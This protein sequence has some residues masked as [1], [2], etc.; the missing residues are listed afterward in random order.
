MGS[1]IRVAAMRGY[2]ELVTQLGADPTQFLARFQIPAGAEYRDDGFVSFEA[3]VR[4]LEASAGDLDCPDFGLRLSARQGLHTLG[5]LA[6]IARNAATLLAGLES[7]ARYLYIHSPALRLTA[8]RSGDLIEF[9][10]EV[11][12]LD[13]PY[14]LQGYE[15][16]MGIAVRIVRLLAGPH[17][18]PSAVSL[19]HGQRGTAAA[20]AEALDCPVHFGRSWCGFALPVELAERPIANADP[21]TRLLATAYLESTYLP[22]SASLSARVAEL[23]RRLLPTGQ[24]SVDAVAAALSL[25]PRALQRRLAQEGTRCQDVIDRE[26]R[27]QAVQY[28]AE[29]DLPISHVAGLLGYSEQSTLN[30]SCRRWFGKTPKQCRD[31]RGPVIP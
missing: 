27:D 3:F 13:G 28:L 4:L 16:S 20:Y 24:C 2:S 18:R 12:E 11:T 29:P 21:E 19:I 1:L 9:A 17:A 10:Y 26:R 22:P 15:L 6:V 14:P 25:H 23:T 5:P 30:R 8:R 31:E 7:I